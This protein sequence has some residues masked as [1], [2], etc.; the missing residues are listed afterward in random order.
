MVSSMIGVSLIAK[1]LG[2]KQ[3][4]QLLASAFCASLPM[5]ILQASS[6]QNDYTVALWIVCLAYF[7]LVMVSNSVIAWPS[8]WL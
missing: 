6:T 2:A 5:G 8:F 4:G 1:Q 7:T 3:G